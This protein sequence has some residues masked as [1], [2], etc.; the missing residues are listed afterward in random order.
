MKISTMSDACLLEGRSDKR[1]EYPGGMN[2]GD[3]FCGINHN[4]MNYQTQRVKL[5]DNIGV[6]KSYRI[7]L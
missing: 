4:F 1:L 5:D 2:L 7:I 3:S 6:L